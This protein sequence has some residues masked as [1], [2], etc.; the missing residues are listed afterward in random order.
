MNKNAYARAVKIGRPLKVEHEVV[1]PRLD[2]VENIV[3]QFFRVRF[4]INVSDN[5]DH[6][7]RSLVFNFIFHGPVLSVFLSEGR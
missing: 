2:G 1:I 6:L 3:I 5:V 7:E 4:R